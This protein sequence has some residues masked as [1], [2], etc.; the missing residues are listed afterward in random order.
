MAF[1]HGMNSGFF[2]K[3]RC[4]HI[5][6][7]R[8]KGEGCHCILIQGRHSIEVEGGFHG[9]KTEFKLPSKSVKIVNKATMANEI[10]DVPSVFFVFFVPKS[11]DPEGDIRTVD[12]HSSDQ[13]DNGFLTS[14]N[15]KR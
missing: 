10:C 2:S 5:V 13:F 7:Q 11:D 8:N 6:D 15:W 14:T 1:F 9:F 12:A 3:Y 4:K